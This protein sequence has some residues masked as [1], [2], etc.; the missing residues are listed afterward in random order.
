MTATMLDVTAVTPSEY[1][2]GTHLPHQLQERGARRG[3]MDLLPLPRAVRG[4]QPGQ[5]LRGTALSGY[6]LWLE[7]DPCEL[8]DTTAVDDYPWGLEEVAAFV[9]TFLGGAVALGWYLKRRYGL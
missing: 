1:G 8:Y 6:G 3:P 9:G 2:A 5:G 4:A 7:D